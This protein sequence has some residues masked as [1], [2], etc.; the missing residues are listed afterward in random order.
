M[1]RAR[2]SL[3]RI[4]TLLAIKRTTPRTVVIAGT[5]DQIK[6]PN[7]TAQMMYVYS[8]GAITLTGAIQ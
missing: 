6:N 3:R 1:F 4:Y 8:K 2:S 7:R 5:P